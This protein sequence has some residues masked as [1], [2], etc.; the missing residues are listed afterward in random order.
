L[1]VT[2]F[3]AEEISQPNWREMARDAISARCF[4]EPPTWRKEVVSG[5][6]LIDDLTSTDFG[7]NNRWIF[8]G[9][10]IGLGLRIASKKLPAADF[11]AQVA[12]LC[13]EWAKERGAERCPSAVKKEIKDRLEDDWLRG[14]IPAS[15]LIEVLWDQTAGY[16]L[17]GSTSPNVVDLV[18]K[19]F[20]RT[21]GIELLPDVPL[22][23]VTNSLRDQLLQTNPIAFTS[24]ESGS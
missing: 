7:D 1:S 13:T 9:S 18:R 6:C 3:V 12:K 14:T 22:D 5:W 10:T 17:V 15:K 4:R 20:H 21:F 2:R 11:K 23:W 24:E 19:T 16:A 8:G